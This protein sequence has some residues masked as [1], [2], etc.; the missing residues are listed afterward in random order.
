MQTKNFTHNIGVPPA[1]SIEELLGAY[2]GL[3]SALGIANELPF[4]IKEGFNHPIK[5]AND[6][7]TADFMQSMSLLKNYSET[8]GPI[9]CT[10][11]RVSNSHVTFIF[12]FAQQ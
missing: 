8:Y 4:P 2:R 1:T 7:L 5:E 9:T 12:S 6:K 11:A 10:D 3:F